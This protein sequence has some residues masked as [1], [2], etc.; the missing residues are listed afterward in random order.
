MF[1]TLFIFAI[2]IVL[3]GA[4]WQLPAWDQASEKVPPDEAPRRVQRTIQPTSTLPPGHPPIDQG[5]PGG[6]PPPVGAATLE[7]DEAATAELAR[8]LARLEDA[9]AREQF[10][11]AFR[12]TFAT[13][14]DA[15]DY[16]QAGAL[17]ERIIAEHPDLAEAYR[18]QAYAVFN[19][20]MSFPQTI[21]LYERAIELD[22]DYGEAHYALAF[23]LGNSD[24]ERGTV[25]FNR[26]MALGI[27]D[28]RNLR[29][30]FF[31]DA[32]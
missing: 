22:P 31:K 18:G 17:F 32:D 16:R 30:R 1:R 2:A 28:S 8:A 7:L 3:I 10:E 15:R 14:R 12:L 19:T 29:E 20:T 13:N 21:A 9:A 23:M 4:L 11:N 5:A 24:P 26:A 6:T 27:P 25:H